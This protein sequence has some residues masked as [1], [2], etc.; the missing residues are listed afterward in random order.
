MANILVGTPLTK[1]EVKGQL[2]DHYDIIII[3]SGAGGL[4]AAAAL[5]K[6]GKKVLVLEQ[7]YTAGGFT[8]TFQRKHQGNTFEW[9]V[10]L[11]YIGKVHLK[12]S[13]PR[14]MFDYLTEG[15]LK[16][17]EFGPVYDKIIIGEKEFNF[18][19][20]EEELKKKLK[21]YFPKE[22]QAI[23]KY[24]QALQ[25]T[26]DARKK[27]YIPQLLPK[28]LQKLTTTLL[29]RKFFK[30]S[31]KT[32]KEV[33]DD[34]TKNNLLKAVLAGQWGD[35]GST[36]E[37][38]SFSMHAMLVQHFFDG[39]AYPIGGARQIATTLT[40]TIEKYGGQVLTLA[41]VEEILIEDNKAIGIL[42]ENKGSN[43]N[44]EGK[45]ITADTIISAVGVPN[46]YQKLLPK[47]M[48]E[49]LKVSQELKTL[50]HSMAHYCLYIGLDGSQE[51]LNLESA[52][53]W[54]YQ[55]EKH[56]QN[57]KNY[58]KDQNQP[59][60]VLYISFPSTK[61]PKWK[62]KHPKLSTVEMIVPA[63]FELFKEWENTSWKQRGENYEQIKEEITKRLLNKLY[64]RIPQ[65]KGKVLYHELSTPLS[66]KHFAA[67]QKG[68]IYGVAPTPQRYKHP[69]MQINTPIENLYL[70]GQD[71]LSVGVVGA[72]MSGAF[73]AAKVL[74]LHRARE[75][76]SKM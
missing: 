19:K 51:E 9:D 24:F 28:P 16:W 14:K 40:K 26:N 70:A 60:P 11:H 15:Q 59:F 6:A 67:Y 21:E 31:N 38:S 37:E 72:L 25:A 55:D 3:G 62:E 71:A 50:K 58:L 44:K 45:K 7:H 18:P 2:K 4:G 23:D 30:W 41:P 5:A 64:Q 43:K 10:G 73:V 27:Y 39:A 48:K 12:D 13:P 34:I 20:G 63:S 32:T 35:Y 17:Q 47:E 36:P 76:L 69:W 53:L 29:A 52:N 1:A 22:Q 65:L 74:G 57:A 54:I 33:L 56:D 61:D 8:H 66:T 42:L 46:S 49:K 75:L 68:E